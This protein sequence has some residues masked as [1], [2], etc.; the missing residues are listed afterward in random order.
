MIQIDGEHYFKNLKA[1]WY[2]TS[3]F[4]KWLDRHVGV[5]P[6]WFDNGGD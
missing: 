2:M 3:I 5:K 1:N 6:D 4:S